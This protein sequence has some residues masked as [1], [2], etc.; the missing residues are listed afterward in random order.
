MSS[1]DNLL[2][3]NFSSSDLQQLADAVAALR[4]S[5]PPPMPLV[6]PASPLVPPLAPDAVPRLVEV[7]EIKEVGVPVAVVAG[8]IALALFLV[9]IA[10]GI[11]H[12]KR[13]YEEVLHPGLKAVS[14]SPCFEGL[15]PPPPPLAA[16][17]EASQL[18][19]AQGDV[20]LSN[21]PATAAVFGDEAQSKGAVDRQALRER[22]A[23]AGGNSMLA[24][25]TAELSM[26]ENLEIQT[27]AEAAVAASGTPEA[28]MLAAVSRAATA[29]EVRALLQ[30]G[31]NPNAAFLDKSVLAL[32]ARHCSAAVVKVLIEGGAT[33]D[34][35][36]PSR[37]P[38]PRS[39]LMAAA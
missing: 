36:V 31:A 11:V 25:E 6:P 16:A 34:M 38:A 33:L 20:L 23:A 7:L 14:E 8:G 22:I 27:R 32:A 10:V 26:A 30:R 21:S 15:V 37:C 2:A 13:L 29:L 9:L 24:A 3:M 1:L 12:R 4:T 35:K 19:P 5:P 39:R 18:T 28:A 17:D